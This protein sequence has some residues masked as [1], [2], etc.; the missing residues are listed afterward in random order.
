MSHLH[1]KS[2]QP[3]RQPD[4]PLPR[5]R[6]TLH[7]A[8]PITGNED[9]LSSLFYE[10][11]RGYTIYSTA[12]GHCCIHGT[13]GCLKLRVKFVCFYE[14]EEA[15]LF[16]A[17]LRRAG[18]TSSDGVERYL[19]PETYVWLNCWKRPRQRRSMRSLQPVS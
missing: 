13:G 10:Q 6:L 2:R 12:R 14:V 5:T 3:V 16:I 7:E 19:P 8:D 15:R 17:H 4:E 18:Y 9:I 11:Y 1:T